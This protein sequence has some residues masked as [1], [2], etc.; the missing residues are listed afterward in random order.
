MDFIKNLLLV[1]L[2]GVCLLMVLV[3]LMQRPKQEGLG[4][5]FGGAMTDQMWGSQTTNVLQKFTVWLAVLFFAIT[6]ALSMIVAS[7]Q[8]KASTLGKIKGVTPSMTAPPEEDGS[9]GGAATGTGPVQVQ[10]AGTPTTTSDP[11]SLAPG[12]DINLSKPTE[13]EIE[14]PTPE[15]VAPDPEPVAPTPE[16]ISP[17]SQPAEENGSTE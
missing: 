8:K 17:D 1:I 10:P 16:P 2:V 7:A 11:I 4:A 12:Q 15:P 3:I 14:A 5:A 9:Q 13:A 6:L